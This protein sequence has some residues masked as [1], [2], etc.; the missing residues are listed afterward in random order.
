[1]SKGNLIPKQIVDKN[2]KV[3]TVWVRPDQGASS[4]Q[5]QSM[6]AAPKL[7][8]GCTPNPDE[9]IDPETAEKFRD[10]PRWGS[11]LSDD[12]ITKNLAEDLNQD[13][14]YQGD[15][16]G[17]WSVGDNGV[18]CGFSIDERGMRLGGSERT[19]STLSVELGEDPENGD[20]MY[21]I[22][23]KDG[24]GRESSEEALSEITL[25]DG[26]TPNVE[27]ME[28]YDGF[29]SKD[30]EQIMHLAKIMRRSAKGYND[31]SVY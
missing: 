24:D 28:D 5:I 6:S 10:H 19:Y 13:H 31:G 26:K 8:G 30:P 16:R 7:S 11:H 21:V 25:E 1:M 14:Q 12:E 20:R 4:G 15:R 17:A 22:S 2:G 3:T 23:A 9:V 27:Y 18:H 29:V